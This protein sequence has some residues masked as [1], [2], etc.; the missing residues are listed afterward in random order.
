MI[1][2][3]PFNDSLPLTLG[4]YYMISEYKKVTGMNIVYI[5]FAPFMTL[6]LT[7]SLKSIKKWL[8]H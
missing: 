7:K 6:H 5:I 1:M 2:F 4:L 3:I 8:S